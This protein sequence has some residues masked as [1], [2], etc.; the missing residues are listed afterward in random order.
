[1]KRTCLSIFILILIVSCKTQD[2][3]TSAE[4]VKKMEIQRFDIENQNRGK[5]WKALADN[6]NQKYFNERKVFI[7]TFIKEKGF[8]DFT[9]EEIFYIQHINIDP[10]YSVS[11]Y[12]KDTVYFFSFMGK[13]KYLDKDSY[14]MVDDFTKAIA[15]G[16][17]YYTKKR[18]SIYIYKNARYNDYELSLSYF[19]NYKNGKLDQLT[20]NDSIIFK[21]KGSKMVVD[22]K[23]LKGFYH[24]EETGETIEY[25]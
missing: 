17:I 11:L 15:T 10:A 25:K 6:Q 24:N 1:M 7:N 12:A 14:W 23:K 8:K 13:A 4:V 20:Y 5:V 19:S 9:M 21:K 16:T 3:Y 22:L 18:D 2:I